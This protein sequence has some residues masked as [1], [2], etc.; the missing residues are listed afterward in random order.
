MKKYSEK[1]KRLISRYPQFSG[2]VPQDIPLRSV[3]DGHDDENPL[4]DVIYGI[5]ET[6]KLPKGDIALYLSN[7]TSPEIRSFI[8]QQIHVEVPETPSFPADSDIDFSRYMREK[9]E[10]RSDYLRRLSHIIKEDR[11]REVELKKNLESKS[12]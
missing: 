5:D 3:P 7:R 1:Q 10:S 4:L 11:L 8:S 2:I 12:E 6:T 9:G